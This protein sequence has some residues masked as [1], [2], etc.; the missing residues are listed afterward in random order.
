LEYH[1][2]DICNDVRACT[3]NVCQQCF[4]AHVNLAK[5]TIAAGLEGVRSPLC[6]GCHYPMARLSTIIREVGKL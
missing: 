6:Q 5:R 3:A 2:I 1:A 4:D